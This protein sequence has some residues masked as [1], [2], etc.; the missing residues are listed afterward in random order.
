MFGRKKSAPAGRRPTYIERGGPGRAPVFSYRAKRS[1]HDTN[2]GRG[3]QPTAAKNNPTSG[4]LAGRRWRQLPTWLALIVIGGALLYATILSPPAKITVDSSVETEVAK[5]EL[6]D[7]RTYQEAADQLLGSWLNR[8]KLT[9]NTDKVAQEMKN[10]FPE[11]KNVG[12]SVPLLGKRPVVRLEP[13]RPALVISGNGGLYVVSADGQALT[14]TNEIPGLAKTLPVV[15]DQSGLEI[16]G[17]ERILPEENVAFITTF[18]QQLQAKKIKVSTLILPPAPEELDI[19]IEGQPYL[20]KTNLSGDARLQ[21]GMYLAT[22]AKLEA[23]KTIPQEVIDTR[24]EERVY[25]K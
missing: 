2:V 7:L 1:D 6:R 21:A 10:R 24:V 18:I 22:K 19:R 12:V 4:R 15:I 5:E 23:D 8:N 16:K 11:L 25:Y 20:I 13:A 3:Q 14:T 9:I 17:G